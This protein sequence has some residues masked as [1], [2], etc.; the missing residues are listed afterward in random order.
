MA[1]PR[2][3][4]DRH[5]VGTSDHS[6]FE[7]LPLARAPVE[8]SN[9]AVHLALCGLLPT[10][11]LTGFFL[12]F[13][14]IYLVAGDWVQSLGRED[15]LEEEMATIS[16][17][18]ALFSSCL[19]S[20]PASGSFPE[21]ALRIRWPKYWNFSFSITP[22]NK[23]SGLISFRIDWFDLLAVQGTLKSL[24]QH[25]SLNFRDKY[26][27]GRPTAAGPFPGLVKLSLVT[28]FPN[29]LV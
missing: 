5:R 19:Q 26:S 23:C 28:F 11:S 10:Q 29:L 8:H 6:G 27:G 16:F 15:T 3:P 7:A 1:T 13:I 20:F 9:Q 18:V 25:H 14:F 2:P 22:S 24:L 4:G 21:L 17:S 12:I